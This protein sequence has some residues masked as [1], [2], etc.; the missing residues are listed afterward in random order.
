M[1]L[2]CQVCGNTDGNC[3]CLIGGAYDIDA[4]LRAAVMHARKAAAACAGTMPTAVL[5]A[6]ESTLANTYA[7]MALAIATLESK[8]R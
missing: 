8:G 6:V 3:Q 1:F 2:P 7:T 5:A 4:I